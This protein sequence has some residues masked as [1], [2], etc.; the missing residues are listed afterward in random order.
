MSQSP[1]LNLC[2]LF[3]SYD[4]YESAIEFPM[5]AALPKQTNRELERQGGDYKVRNFSFVKPHCGA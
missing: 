4:N 5:I 1:F 3:K 2:G